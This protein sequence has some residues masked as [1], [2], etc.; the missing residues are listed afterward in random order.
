MLMSVDEIRLKC[1][2]KNKS[3]IDK[4]V[5]VWLYYFIRPASF[6]LTAWLYRLKISADQA[7]LLGFFVGLISLFL[8]YSGQFIY[9]ALLLNLFYVI[10]CVDGNLA[11]LGTPTKVGEYLDAISGDVIN[12]A[13]PPLFLI[14]ALKQG[15]LGSLHSIQDIDANWLI[16]ILLFIQL[17]TVLANQRFKLI[18]NQSKSIESYKLST[19]FELV[20]RN[21]Y[22]AAFLYP[23][24]LVVSILG[25][26]Q[27]LFIYL[28]LTAPLFYGVSV[29]RAISFR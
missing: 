10:D 23:A 9:S 3:N 29:A 7:T 27:L 17:L 25:W 14:G 2:D 15:H 12:F 19:G 26:Y 11:R 22:G 4:K 13:F 16:S 28:L 24:V 6:Y 1:Y 5:S 8:A 18:I 20:I 21:G